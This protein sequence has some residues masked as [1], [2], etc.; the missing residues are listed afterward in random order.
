MLAVEHAAPTMFARIG[1][2]RVLNCS[3]VRKFSAS[4]NDP[5]GGAGS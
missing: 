3:H 4:G 5:H 1:A 2:M